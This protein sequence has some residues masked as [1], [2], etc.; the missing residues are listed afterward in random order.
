MSFERSARRRATVDRKTVMHN[1]IRAGERAFFAGISN[2][3]PDIYQ[4][5]TGQSHAWMIGWH[6][7]KAGNSVWKPPA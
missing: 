6:N 7:A 2:T 5:D 4:S 3:V 1:A